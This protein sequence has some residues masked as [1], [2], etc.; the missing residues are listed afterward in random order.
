EIIGGERFTK[1]FAIAELFA[2]FE[3]VSLAPALAVLETL[4]PTW[5][6]TTTLAV[7]D[8]PTARLPSVNVTTLPTRLDVPCEVLEE[9][10][11]VLLGKV[12]VNFTP[13]AAA[14]PLLITVKL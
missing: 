1:V 3:S 4:P 12:F 5:G 8:P 9:T 2:E 11:V 7:A 14:G 10:N 13:V 6:E